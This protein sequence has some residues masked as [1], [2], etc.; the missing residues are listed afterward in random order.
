MAALSLALKVARGRVQDAF[1]LAADMLF[2]QGRQGT[3]G[4]C[5]LPQGE[6][7]WKTSFGFGVQISQEGK[8]AGQCLSLCQGQET[9]EGGFTCAR[10][11]Q[12][13]NR[14]AAQSFG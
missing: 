12:N 11:S 9:E 4:G 14:P 1:A 10:F 8:V 2:G 6:K 13:H 7:N 3:C 5:S